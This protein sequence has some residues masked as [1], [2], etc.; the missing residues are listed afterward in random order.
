MPGRKHSLPAE[1]LL[2]VCKPRGKLEEAAP[3]GPIPWGLW[4]YIGRLF[5]DDEIW[6]APAKSS[7][8][9]G[10]SACNN[11]KLCLGLLPSSWIP[12]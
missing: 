9:Y 7:W 10:K 3:P 4:G 6:Q 8:P 11:S 2:R 1:A 5:K 12:L